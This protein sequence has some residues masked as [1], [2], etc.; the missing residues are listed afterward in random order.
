MEYATKKTFHTHATSVLHCKHTRLKCQAESAYIE[1][2]AD[3]LP[4][5]VYVY[6]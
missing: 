6:V 4:F 1:C 3:L 5:A 2:V